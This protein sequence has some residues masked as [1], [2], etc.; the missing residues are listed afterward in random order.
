M[1]TLQLN[2]L[3]QEGRFKIIKMLGQG[4]FGITYLAEHVNLGKKVAIK[5]FF[6][7][8]LNSRKEDGSIT[9]MS[10]GRLSKS[11]CQKFQKEAV[12]LCHLDHPNIV[13]V[14]DSFAENG[15]F[16]YVMD[17]IEGQNLN[18]Y[19]KQHQVSESEAVEIIK[20]VA[21]ALIYMHETHHMLHLDL[22]PGNVMRRNSD[23]H[24]FLIDFGLSKHYSN[25]GHPET[26]TT[27]G[28]GTAG[29]APIEQANQ[30]KDGEFRPTI[31]VY[32]LGATLYKL[33]TLETPPSAVD[34]V[35][36]EEL[37]TDK[38]TEHNILG[39]I[40][41][42]I[43]KAMCPNVKKRIQTIS[44]FVNL[45]ENVDT[46]LSNQEETLFEDFSTAM[47]FYNK[48]QYEKAFPILEQLANSGNTDAMVRLGLCYYWYEG[49]EYNEPSPSKCKDWM[50]KAAN[51]GNSEA[52]L[53]LGYYLDLLKDDDAAVE[54]IQKAVEAGNNS[55][56]VVMMYY[57]PMLLKMRSENGSRMVSVSQE[58]FSGLLQNSSSLSREEMYI[59]ACCYGYGIGTEGDPQ[60][61]LYW[62]EKSSDLGDPEA[63]NT[64]GEIYLKGTNGVVKNESEALRLFKLS[65]SK[66]YS[67]ALKNVADCYYYGWGTTQNYT[68]AIEWYN[69]AIDTGDCD[70]MVRL[71]LCYMVGNG[72]AKDY[73]K[74]EELFLRAVAE[75]PTLLEDTKV[76]ALNYLGLIYG[77]GGYGITKDLEKSAKYFEPST[78]S[79][80]SP[81]YVTIFKYGKVSEEFLYS[82]Y[83]ETSK[84]YFLVI[85]G[86][87][88]R[89]GFFGITKDLEKSTKYFEQ[90]ALQGIPYGQYFYGISLIAGI[91]VPVDVDKGVVWIKKAADHKCEDAMVMLGLCYMIGN[92][93]ARDYKKSEKWFLRANALNYLGLIYGKGGYGITK[94]SEKSIKYFEQATLSD[95]SFDFD[96]VEGLHLASLLNLSF[97]YLIGGMSGISC[98]VIRGI[99]NDLKVA[100]KNALKV[101]L[102]V[103][104]VALEVVLSIFVCILIGYIIHET[105]EAIYNYFDK[106]EIQQ[107]APQNKKGNIDAKIKKSSEKEKTLA[108]DETDSII[109]AE[110]QRAYEK[111]K[112]QETHKIQTH[113]YLSDQWK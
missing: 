100:L 69:K 82:K 88:C 78:E 7:R 92:G 109:D 67:T 97:E 36:D 43:T 86:N 39:K 113:E 80:I 53:Y 51:L 27:I 3:L 105:Y 96:E 91:G 17:Y 14:T 20:S 9:G 40:A 45:L 37:L 65:A 56:K 99:V 94:D 83:N 102:K 63:Q 30:A 93:V 1:Q 95:I 70:A 110:I 29:Y 5:E 33:V 42:V 104:K 21:G 112:E 111:A 32:A 24:I 71:G 85:L 90:A 47:S 15:T 4:S 2:T 77:E 38:L 106:E 25:D 52:M 61:A 18:D 108:A 107:P 68:K 49:I 87:G 72:V 101:A 103:A 23:G 46:S 6:M 89:E 74:S 8:E 79:R 64:L 13:R 76:E 48:G 34:L 62:F 66:Q 31:D 16:Y 44:A 57:C 12:N 75:C 19:I 28:L 60:K 98:I 84:P 11:Y 73:K 59:L 41:E 58:G 10:D 35:S 22:K 55:A 50:L 26:S 81:C 54:Y